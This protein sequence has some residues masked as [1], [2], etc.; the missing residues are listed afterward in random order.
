MNG[1]GGV[2]VAVAVTAAAPQLQ[3]NVRYVNWLLWLDLLLRLQWLMGPLQGRCS[4]PAA[5]RS[6]IARASSAAEVG[7]NEGG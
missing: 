1:G 3:D 2:A 4:S 6:R 7:L 5:R